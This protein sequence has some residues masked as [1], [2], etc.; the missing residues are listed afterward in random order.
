M[1]LV[2]GIDLGTTNSTI[3]V[4][5][6]EKPVIMENKEGDRITP[7]VVSISDNGEIT[8]GKYAKNEIKSK[9]ANT[10]IEVKRLMGSK[11]W[12]NVN[13][14]KYLPEEISAFIL[15]YLKESVEERL[16]EKIDE[17]VI[18]V[19]AAF[20]NV[21]R[22]ATKDAGEIAGLKVDRIINEPTAAALSYGIELSKEEIV[23]VY[24]LGGGTFD[25]SILE[26]AD[27]IFEARSSLGDSKLGGT[28]FDQLLLDLIVDKFNRDKGINLNDNKDALIRLRPDIEE[29]K[30][31]LSSKEV[32]EF[33]IPIIYGIVDDD[34][35]PIGIDYNISRLEFEGL[36]RK[37]VEKTISMV[38]QA[39]ENAELNISKIDRVIV[40]GGSTRIPLVKRL[41]ENL[42]GNKL[43]YSE[44]PDEAIGL[45]AAIQAG[46]KSGAFEDGE[47]YIITDI[48]SHTLGIDVMSYWENV[49]VFG[50]FSAILN[51]DST[52]PRR[53]NKI[54]AT[55]VDNQTIVSV[56]VYQGEEPI[57]KDNIY[58]GSVEVKGIPSG[59]AASEKIDVEFNYDL[60]GILEVNAQIVS[61]KEVFSKIFTGVG[62][63]EGEKN[64]SKINVASD[65][66]KSKLATKVLTLITT[67]ELKLGELNDIDKAQVKDIIQQIKD[68]VLDNDEELVD[69]LDEKLTD[70]LFDFLD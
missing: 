69:K 23:L 8:V 19:P 4:L 46:I 26:I 28:D 58:I 6:N 21:Q 70:I 66:K 40:V 31:V 12:I 14:R 13:E 41:L 1:G 2:V 64:R 45:G 20:N 3:S 50:L 35:M 52:I 36:I 25:V 62:M 7:S 65:W 59:P 34:N 9:P 51:K 47:N 27:G 29:L 33:T 30:K 42:F 67:A 63:S 44:N 5:R 53:D 15:K 49:P 43:S 17:A 11:E 54:Y 24:D 61:T 57:V 16:G 56:D 10:V 48:A 32:A 18:T 38:K 55:S 22:N 60:N 39:I 68:A 37:H